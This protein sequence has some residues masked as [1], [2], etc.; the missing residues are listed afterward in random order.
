MKVKGFTALERLS[1]VYKV[2]PIAKGIA[3]GTSKR[4]RGI[5]INCTISKRNMNGNNSIK[6]SAFIMYVHFLCLIYV[7]L[8]CQSSCKVIVL[9][10]SQRALVHQFP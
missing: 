10:Y 9:L 5:H 3:T 1:P 2:K 7:T 6:P 4:V 8:P